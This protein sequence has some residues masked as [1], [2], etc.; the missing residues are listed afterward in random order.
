MV[1][2]DM[3][4][5]LPAQGPD[6]GIRGRTHAAGLG[7]DR[8]VLAVR[9]VP[10]RDDLGALLGGEHAGPQLGSGLVGKAVADADR[11]FR[12]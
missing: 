11:V 9:F 10:D 12:Q 3:V 6:G 5:L 4:G 8:G 1:G 2:I 7:T